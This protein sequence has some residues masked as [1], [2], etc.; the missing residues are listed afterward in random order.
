MHLQFSCIISRPRDFQLNMKVFV[1]GATGY[2]GFAV[3]AEMARAGH[4]VFGLSRSAEK[5]TRLAAHEILPVIGDMANPAS[6][7]QAASE[8]GVLIHC[9]AEY[10]ARYMELDRSTV[11]SLLDTASAAGGG[12][13]VLYTSGCWLLGNSG[14]RPV[15]EHTPI[16]PPPVL[17]PRAETERMILDRTASTLRTVI[18]RPGCVYGASGG[19]TASWFQSAAQDGSA[20]IVGDGHFRWTMVHINDLAV[21]YRLAAESILTGEI[22]NISDDSR[23]TVLE[24]AQAANKQVTGTDKVTTIP[25]N[26]AEKTIG[27]TAVCLTFDQHVDSSKA[28]KMLGWQARHSGFIAGVECYYAAWKASA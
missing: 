13:L 14:D 2:I 17:A 5:A 1:T 15:Y 19:L 26:E 6:Y 21:A 11:T 28:R 20:R 27:P 12:R 8:A 16:N 7:A 18:I 25:V 10:S 3:A 22:F 4:T 23:S 9:A 24:C